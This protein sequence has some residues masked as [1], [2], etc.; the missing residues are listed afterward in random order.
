MATKIFV[1]ERRKV[2]T[3]RKEAAFPAVG[4][5]GGDL[6]IYAHPQERPSRS[7]MKPVRPLSGWM[8]AKVRATA[9][10]KASANQVIR[11]VV[12]DGSD[13]PPASASQ[14]CSGWFNASMI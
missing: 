4:V 11:F 1:R 13:V 14:M 6:K 12:D 8:P 9:R 2:E 7:P 5:S 3:K 10:A